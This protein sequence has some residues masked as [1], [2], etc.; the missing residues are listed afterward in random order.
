MEEMMHTGV[1]H[2]IEQMHTCAPPT[3]HPLFSRLPSNWVAHGVEEQRVEHLHVQNNHEPLE[4]SLLHPIQLI[5][6]AAVESVRAYTVLQQEW[7][8]DVHSPVHAKA[9]Q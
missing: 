8:S 1:K 3:T 7:V 2:Y 9:A 6:L 4:V 5:Q